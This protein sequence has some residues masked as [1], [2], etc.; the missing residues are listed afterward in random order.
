MRTT[1][2]AA[3][4]DGC[5]DSSPAAENRADETPELTAD[6]LSSR[7]WVGVPAS[8]LSEEATWGSNQGLQPRDLASPAQNLRS[9]PDAGA[10]ATRRSRR[11]NK[12]DSLSCSTLNSGTVRVVPGSTT[13]RPQGLSVDTS[14]TTSHS[15]RNGSRITA[16]FGSGASTFSSTGL[17]A[18][19]AGTPELFKFMADDSSFLEDN[20]AMAASLIGAY[21]EV[22]TTP[23]PGGRE[24]APQRLPGGFAADGGIGTAVM[25]PGLLGG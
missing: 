16:T 18:S 19:S 20:E 15:G 22:P 1:R 5:D 2:V 8:S 10:A 9:Y 11:R 13:N 3:A 25:R 14:Q 21:A 12:R 7:V 4:V 24:G 23:S 17:S 6:V